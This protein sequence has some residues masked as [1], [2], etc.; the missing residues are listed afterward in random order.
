MHMSLRTLLGEVDCMFKTPSHDCVLPGS[1]FS[2]QQKYTRSFP[3]GAERLRSRPR[4]RG[5]RHEVTP[6]RQPLICTPHLPFLAAAAARARLLRAAPS[7]SGGW[8][9]RAA[10]ARAAHGAPWH[11]RAP[12]DCG[13]E[14]R[15]PYQAG[16]AGPWRKAAPLPRLCAC[17]QGRIVGGAGKGAGKVCQARRQRELVSEERIVILKA[18][19]FVVLPP[20]ARRLRFLS[21][22][23]GREPQGEFPPVS[24][25]LAGTC[26]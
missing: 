9:F 12:P 7:Q 14:P 25:S 19:V 21:A 5:C 24:T 20:R 22:N 11:P 23:K 10:R 3:T 6:V 26:A 16:R 2:S 8:A 13:H 15:P 18:R 4:I 17:P 1:N